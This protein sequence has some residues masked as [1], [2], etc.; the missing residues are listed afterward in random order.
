MGT[1]IGG[2]LGGIGSIGGAMIQAGA[3]N[4]AAKQ[5]L[6]GYTYLTQGGGKN[7]V[8]NAVNTGTKAGNAFAQLI[9]LEQPTAETGNAF[10]Q[11]LDS[12][13]YQFQLGEG[14]RAITSSAAARGVLNSGAT[15]KAL[16]EYGQNLATNSFNNYLNLL[17]GAQV[18]GLNA[19]TGVA[20]AGTGA[21]SQAAQYNMAVGNA[22]AQGLSGGL[23]SIA[24]IA[25]QQQQ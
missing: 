13:G 18:T 10:Q 6:T 14:Q 24:N 21:G 8:N 15:A 25:A 11:Y 16:T 19:A 1:V 4:R 9:G 2:I 20:N 22:W 5:A 12:T 3:A 7:L 23:G 17:G